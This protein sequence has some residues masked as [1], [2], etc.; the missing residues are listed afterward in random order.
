LTAI[1]YLYLFYL[2]LVRYSDSPI[3]W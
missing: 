1:Q 2:Y 3:V